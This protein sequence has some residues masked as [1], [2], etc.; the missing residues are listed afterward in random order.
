MRKLLSLLLLSL[1]SSAV[2]AA[3]GDTLL[4]VTTVGATFPSSNAPVYDTRNNHLVL[5]YDAGTDETS[6]F[7]LVMPRHY[8]GT[9][10][11]TVT[12]YWMS[13]DQTSNAVVWNVGFERQNDDGFD[14]D[15]D[16]FAAVNTST[17]TTASAAGELDYCTITFTDGADMDSVAVGEAFRISVV[18][19]AD[20]GSDNMTGDAQLLAV[21]IKET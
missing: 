16:G 7:Q 19:D 17:C 2:F 20:N 5:E 13:V 6:Y 21:E 9:T 15:G 18:R 1:L 3:S 4:I 8:A 14:L 10:G 11:V 12:I